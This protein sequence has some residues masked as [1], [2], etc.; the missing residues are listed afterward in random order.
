MTMQSVLHV[1]Q[2]NHCSL[3][4]LK[5]SVFSTE[6]SKSLPSKASCLIR[7]ELVRSS[8]TAPYLIENKMSLGAGLLAE[9]CVNRG[10]MAP[11]NQNHQVSNSPLATLSNTMTSSVFVC[12]LAFDLGTESQAWSILS[13]CIAMSHSSSFSLPP[14]LS[15]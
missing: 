1:L 12:S 6:L 11:S 13:M 5:P 4:L 10:G 14:M 9:A 3:F 8:P 7:L 15:L 2:A